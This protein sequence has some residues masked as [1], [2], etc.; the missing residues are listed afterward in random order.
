MAPL[1]TG[2]FP[3]VNS[4]FSSL[5]SPGP[6]SS[7]SSPLFNNLSGSGSGSGSGNGSGSGSGN[8]IGSNSSSGNVTGRKVGSS[9]ILTQKPFGQK[10]DIR[11]IEI[12]TEMTDAI[13]MSIWDV[14]VDRAG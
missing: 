5:V 14:V 1:W 6:G 2:D 10:L 12:V 8:G 3:G 11:V 4:S 13:E 9:G 7:Y